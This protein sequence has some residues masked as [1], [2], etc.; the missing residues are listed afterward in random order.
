MDQIN[1]CAK[2]I[3]EYDKECKLNWFKFKYPKQELWGKRLGLPENNENNNVEKKMTEMHTKKIFEN[4][5]EAFIE[6]LKNQPKKWQQLCLDSTSSSKIPSQSYNMPSKYKF[7]HQG[8]QETCVFSSLAS[9]LSYKGYNDAAEIISR[10]IQ[11]SF[12][13]GDP[14]TYAACLL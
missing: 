11:G 1:Q 9:A 4:E 5:T 13:Y 6:K 8:G 12:S 3:P 14:M 10:N 2:D 7:F